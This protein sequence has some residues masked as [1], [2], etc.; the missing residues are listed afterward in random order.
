ALLE[1]H[2]EG[3]ASRR[4]ESF[5]IELRCFGPG[6]PETWVSLHCSLFGD[7]STTNA[8]LIFQL[9]D[10]TSRRRAEGDLHHIAFHDS[11]TDLAN[12]SCFHERLSGAV[13]RQRVD[14]RASFAV[15]YLDLDRFKIVNDSLGHQAGDQLL[16]IAAARISAQVR[17]G[18]LVAR[19]G[20]DEFAV[21]FEGA[22]GHDDME[23]LGARL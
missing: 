7:T 8:G 16:K 11:L 10:I 3:V 6:Q 14:P 17:S 13:Q 18:D 22:P 15:M 23:K 1:G 9:H 4:D 19:L 5:S 21:L 20:G 12:R 2:A